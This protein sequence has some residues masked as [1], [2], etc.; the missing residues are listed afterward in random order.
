MMLLTKFTKM[1][2]GDRIIFDSG[3]GYNLGFYDSETSEHSVVKL[4]MQT[5]GY[6]PLKT[7]VAR[8]SLMKYTKD[9]LIKMHKKYGE[10][11]EFKV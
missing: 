11:K 9:N 10:L 7:I 8:D 4:I 5:N 6:D 3:F 2:K 1:K